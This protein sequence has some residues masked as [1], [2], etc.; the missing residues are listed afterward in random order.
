MTKGK[1]ARKSLHHAAV[2]RELRRL[3]EQGAAVEQQ[4]DL[5]RTVLK[6]LVHRLGDEV[7]LSK[8]DFRR[9]SG[10]MIEVSM[11]DA[12]GV[13]ISFKPRQD[14]V[15]RRPRPRWWSWLLTGWWERA[16]G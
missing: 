6:A 8:E 2:E 9:A 3:H 16:D 11:A 1:R 12:G 7:E 4:R 14:A 5:V 15:E 13:H 10:G